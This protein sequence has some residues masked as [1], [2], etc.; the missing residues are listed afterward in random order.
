MSTTESSR[1]NPVAS[2]MCWTSKTCILDHLQILINL[3]YF[4]IAPL[5]LMPRQ[6]EA[7]HLAQNSI[8]KCPYCRMLHGELGRIAHLTNPLK[9]NDS[10]EVH[11]DD[12]PEVELFVNFGKA[13]GATK[14]VNAVL[15][16]E[17]SS[18]IESKYGKRVA[19]ATRAL[20]WFL[21]W[22]SMGGNTINYFI[23]LRL[24]PASSWVSILCS[25]LSSSFGTAPFL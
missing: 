18:S 16:D 9:L 12:I 20:C 23:F 6:A 5:L 21:L 22:G 24:F 4:F 19:V 2:K 25:S 14:G 7:L 13:F 8:N 3:P 15:L 11:P 17:C 1:E 10:G